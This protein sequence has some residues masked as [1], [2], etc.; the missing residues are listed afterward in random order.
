MSD[1]LEQFIYDN[2]E[3][4]DFYEPDPMLWEK[5]KLRPKT[6]T[7]PISYFF[8]AAAIILVIITI[9]WGVLNSGLLN[10]SQNNEEI[11]HL[12]EVNQWLK[13]G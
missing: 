8:K 3:G 12:S 2:R 11:I 5:I 10:K 13:N 9:S 1:Q 7:I 6:I 4:F